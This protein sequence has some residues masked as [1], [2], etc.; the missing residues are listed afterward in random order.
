MH[1][2]RLRLCE[3]GA[4]YPDGQDAGRLQRAQRQPLRHAKPNSGFL[5]AAIVQ[6]Q[7]LISHGSYMYAPTT[8]GPIGTTG[9]MVVQFKVTA[10]P[11][12]GVSQYRIRSY[13]TGVVP[14]VTGLGVADDL[15]SLMVFTEPQAIALAG[16]EV[17]VKLPLCED[18]G[19]HPS[20]DT[21]APPF[22]AP[23]SMTG[24]KGGQF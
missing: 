6:P 23:R 24:L 11:V 9:G 10:D 2:Q 5:A 22:A 14:T 8:V 4:D 15:G 18:A 7:A 16:G 21:W 20:S 13:L 12:S 1:L 19:A 17:I 3:S